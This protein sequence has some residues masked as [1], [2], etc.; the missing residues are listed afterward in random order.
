MELWVIGCVIMEAKDTVSSEISEGAQQRALRSGQRLLPPS[1]H[2]FF[3]SA[4][5]F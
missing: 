1:C 5:Q 3:N 4:G 2:L